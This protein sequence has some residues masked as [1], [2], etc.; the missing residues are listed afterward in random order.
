M[1]LLTRD[2]IL[3]ADDLVTR[4]VE[5]PEWRPRGADPN[6]KFYVRIRTLTAEQ[7][8]KWEASTVVVKNGQQKLNAENLRARLIALCIVNEN[9]ELLF[10]PPDIRRLG[11]KSS[12]ALQRVFNACQELNAVTDE[13]IEE[14]AEGFGESQDDALPSA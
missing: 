10:T 3:N 9:N 1:A 8:D 7:R 5:V 4:D 13:D 2:Q 11:N 12:A 6:E 14:M